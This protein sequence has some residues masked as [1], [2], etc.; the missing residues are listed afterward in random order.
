MK[1]VLSQFILQL[2]L[3]VLFTSIAH[4]DFGL[5]LGSFKNKHEAQ[6]YSKGLIQQNYRAYIEEIQMVSTGLWYRVCVG[7]FATRKESRNQKKLLRSNGFDGDI[8][9]VNTAGQPI[10]TAEAI[11]RKKDEPSVPPS[12][13]VQANPNTHSEKVTV[14]V[15]AKPDTLSEKA[16]APGQ[17]HITLK[18]DVSEEPDLAGYKV[19]YDTDPGPP[20][21]PDKADY[22]DEGPSPI[23]V[24][25]DM[26]EITLHGLNDAKDYFFSITSFNT[27]G[28]ESDYSTEISSIQMISPKEGPS[29]VK[30]AETEEVLKETEYELTYIAPGDTL[31]IDVP[32]QIEMS[33]AYDVDPNGNLHLLM[34]GKVHVEGLNLTDLNA[35]LTERLKKYIQK[36]DKISTQML[37]RKRYIYVQGGVRYPGWYRVSL[38]TDLDDIIQGAGGLVSGADYS[39]IRLRRKTADGYKE[40]AAKGKIAFQADDILVV[41]VPKG[42]RERVDNGDLLFVSIPQRQPPGRV[43]SPVDTADLT[44]TLGQNQLTV[45]RNGYIYIPDYGHFSVN[46]LTP[47]EITEMITNRL[48]KYLARLSRVRVNIIEKQ[49]FIQIFGHVTNPGWYNIPESANAQAALSTAGDAIDGSVMSDVS[50]HRELKGITK[51]I[52]VNLYQFTITGDPRILTPLHENDVL[53]VPISSSFGSIKRTLRSWEPPTERLEEEELIKKKV[54][55]FGA[56]N[57]PGIYEPYEDMD[58]LDLFVLASG[59]RLEADLSKVVIIRNNRVEVEFNFIDYL[60]HVGTERKGTLKIPKVFHGDTVY[61][62]FVESK[63]WEPK[64]DKVLYVTGKVRGPGQFKLW[65]QMTVLQAIAL[66]GGL[67][68][69]ADSE[70]ITIVR[71]VAGKQENIPFNYKKGISGKY[72]EL[73]IY[74][75]GDDTIV[76]P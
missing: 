16:T 62:R 71:I 23:I 13:P 73:N 25:S 63:V 14:P 53:F 3:I 33:H 75:Q 17:R 55:I 10:V 12:K 65:D 40:T 27:K 46:N 15:Q 35:K 37:E 19:Y 57:N 8:F 2:F 58:L 44:R 70:H 34:I 52:K 29:I 59:E 18:W 51:H 74:L 7:P 66:A 21:N 43:P 24:G 9:I 20:Y 31:Q 39:K 69:W 1:K 36:G 4:A 47:G 54:R 72:P 41:P 48:P 50:I 45:D 5:M 22:A 38:L 49:H 68:E 64:E 42:Y 76:V 67:T 56:I 28:L 26:T 30:R 60:K 61:V 11:D 6:K 32:H